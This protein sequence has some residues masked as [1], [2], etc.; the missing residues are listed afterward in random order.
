MNLARTLLCEGA[1][2]VLYFVYGSYFEWLFHRFLF[3]SPKLIYRTF[4]EH[5][6][7][8]HQIYKSDHTYHAHEDRPHKVPMDWWA[9]PMMIAVHIPL[10][11]FVQWATKL[12]TFWGGI[13]AITV[14]YSLYESFHWAMHVPSASRFLSRFRLWRYLDAHHLVH[15]KYML[16]NLNVIMP[17]ADVTFGTLRDVNGKKIGLGDITSRKKARAATPFSA[18]TND[19]DRQVVSAEPTEHAINTH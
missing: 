17:L 10:F 5:T 2:F 14:Y 9:L 7:V 8:H 15:H 11:L 12:P 18:R 13:A 16:S 6:L 1:A 3:H 4:R 19:K